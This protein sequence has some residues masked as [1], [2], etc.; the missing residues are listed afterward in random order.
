MMQI[1]NITNSSMYQ[2]LNLHLL[3]DVKK[4]KQFIELKKVKNILKQT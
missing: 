3:V 1:E 4:T 2:V